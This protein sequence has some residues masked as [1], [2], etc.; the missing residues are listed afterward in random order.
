MCEPFCTQ[1]QEREPRSTAVLEVLERRGTL[2]VWS[3][4]TGQTVAELLYLALTSPRGVAMAARHVYWGL[5]E[6]LYNPASNTQL[7]NVPFP[8]G[9][10][11][12]Q[13]CVSATH[14]F[15]LIQRIPGEY[16]R[17][18]ERLTSAD[19]Y[20]M[21]VRAYPAGRFQQK[22]R[23]LSGAFP[24]R[25]V[26]DNSLEI[27]IHADADAPARAVVEQEGRLFPQ[28]DFEGRD[29]KNSRLLGDVLL[30]SALTNY[31][32]RGRYDS[33]RDCDRD[34]GER[35]VL[36]PDDSPGHQ[37]LYEDILNGPTPALRPRRSLVMTGMTEQEVLQAVRDAWTGGHYL[38]QGILIDIDRGRPERVIDGT[39]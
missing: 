37:A 33:A 25:Q 17:M 14:I 18:V 2:H 27:R 5:L 9:D 31:V 10:L 34:S 22:R 26:N 36:P 8:D 23:W 3:G 11:Q 24:F 30:Q 15:N 28:Y 4:E 6:R 19:A 32:M 35:G 7:I 13:T 29:Q 20:F 21:I 39:G 16:A 12:A 38:S 1:L